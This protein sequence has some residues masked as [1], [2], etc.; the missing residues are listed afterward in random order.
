ME[1]LVI[2]RALILLGVSDDSPTEIPR[3]I[4]AAPIMTKPSRQ[5]HA[6]NSLLWFVC[7]ILSFWMALSAAWWLSSRIEYGY[8]A[9][10]RL[11]AIDEHIARYAP[12]HP[13]KP[14]FARLDAAGHRQAFASITAAVHGRGVAL[15][16]IRYQPPGHP[17][18]PLLDDDEVRHLRDVARLLRLAGS[19]TLAALPLWLLGMW[20]LS[21]Q[22]LP[23]L[24]QRALT[25][26][27]VSATGLAVLLLVGPKALFYQFHVWLF[28]PE[29]PWFFYWEESLMSTLMKAPYLF[30]AIAVQI[31]VLAVLLVVPIH[32]LGNRFGRLLRR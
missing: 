14:G 31:V 30:G 9:W 2:I 17:A 19:A 20:W 25:V 16:S 26:M 11:L 29:N 13:D 15:E 22:P 12:H 23:S 18:L 21:R 6:K 32:W 24:R 8:P 28:P 7:A 27:A 4:R 1:P 3:A 10:Y 5:G